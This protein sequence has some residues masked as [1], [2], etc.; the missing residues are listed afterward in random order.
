MKS[1][2]F[3][4]W[5]HLWGYVSNF[6][7]RLVSSWGAPWRSGTP[8]RQ[9]RGID[10]LVAI[11]RSERAQ[12]KSCREPRCSPRVEP[13]CRETFGVASRVP[14]TVLHFNTDL[15]LHLTRCRGQGPHLGMT[16]ESRGFSQGAAGFS[17]YDS[18]FRLPLVLADWHT[19]NITIPEELKS[20]SENP[21]LTYLYFINYENIIIPVTFSFWQILQHI[22][23]EFIDLQ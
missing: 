1:G 6:F 23:H 16:G 3:R 7:V 9:S 22:Q 21:Y 8:S 4:T 18:E 14:S 2:S 17:S 10:H 12:L 13:V 20:S 15:G 11:R 5:H 19:Q